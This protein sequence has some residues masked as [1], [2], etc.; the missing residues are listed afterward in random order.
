M[1]ECFPPKIENTSRMSAL[2]TLNIVLE[3]LASAPRQEKEVKGM[4]IRNK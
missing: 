2:T 3:V 4:Q 1:T